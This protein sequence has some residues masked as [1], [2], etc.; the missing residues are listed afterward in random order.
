M[1]E[2]PLVGAYNPADYANLNV[3]QEIKD[4]FAHITS[5][6]PQKIDLDTRFKPFIP[7]YIPAVGEVD[8]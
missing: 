4:L 5:F 3:S 6:Q 7:D 2:K 8:A 1:E